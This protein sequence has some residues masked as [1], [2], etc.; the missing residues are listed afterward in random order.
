MSLN[1]FHLEAL[2]HTGVHKKWVIKAQSNSSNDS[3][4]SNKDLWAFQ[5]IVNLHIGPFLNVSAMDDAVKNYF[6]HCE[7]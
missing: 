6:A 3:A 5:A 1:L 7:F 2:T 4:S